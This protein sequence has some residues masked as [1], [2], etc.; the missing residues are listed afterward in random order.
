MAAGAGA[1]PAAGAPQ[2]SCTPASAPRTIAYKQISGVPA[3]LTSLDVWAPRR[4]CRPG[5]RRSPVV[6]WVHGGAYQT[7]D[8]RNGVRNKVRAFNARG[9]VFVS[10]NYR[11]TRP[12]NPGS[13]RYPDH[14]RDVAAAVAWTRAH[15][16]RSGGDPRRI[17]LLGHS[18]GADIVSN[19]T[20]NPRWLRE[21][22]LSLRA[23]RCAGPL[24]TAGFDKTR[25]AHSAAQSEQWRAALGNHPGYKSDT[26]A[27]LLARA[28][29]GIP[30]TI[31][32]VRGTNLRR[33]IQTAFADALRRA[34]V[35]TSVIDA[36]SLSHAEVSRRIGAPGDTVMTPPLMRFLGRCFDR[37]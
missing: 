25:A 9:W 29:T 5:G 7:G 4:S 27:T 10:V 13:A 16:S 12:G 3:N 6:L 35:R 18:A 28:G 36:S 20:T 33:S 23:V 31:T 26:S 37:G 14:F 2:G 30:R 19:V 21:R 32:V 17:A 22:R 11:L 1:A 8:K 15:I 24:D 34:R